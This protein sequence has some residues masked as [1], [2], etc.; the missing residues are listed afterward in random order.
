MKRELLADL[1]AQLFADFDADIAGYVRLNA[2]RVELI[3]DR[4]ATRVSGLAERVRVEALGAPERAIAARDAGADLAALVAGAREQSSRIAAIATRIETISETFAREARHERSERADPAIPLDRSAG[5]A[6]APP[7]LARFDPQTYEHGLRPERWRVVVL[8]ALRRGKSSLINT[9]AGERILGDEGSEIEMRFPVHVRYGA[10]SKAYALGD[11]AAW[12]PIALDSALDAATRTP[13]L[14]ET[15]WTLPRQLVLVHTPAFDSGR[16]DA[17]LIAFAAAASASEL[18]ALFSR[19]LSDREL[20]VYGR[21][22]GLGKAMTFVHTIADNEAPTERRNVVA[23]AGRYLRERAIVPQ[24][25]FTIS[26]H[27]FRSAQAASQAPAAWNELG[28][29]I[30]TLAA[31]AEEHMLRLDRAERERAALERLTRP[32]PSAT[33][34]APARRRSLLDK[35]FGRG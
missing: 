20:E 7:D 17:E 25:V 2:E 16:P 19:Q 1:G 18:I 34:A 29:L 23:L 33:N 6:A 3:A 11:D 14:I 30:S 26:T 27:E 28:A 22:A 5:L 35:L 31:H 8:G 21:M 10:A 32:E 13:V 24:R 15:P 12:D 4:L 9:I